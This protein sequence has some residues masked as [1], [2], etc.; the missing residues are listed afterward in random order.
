MSINEKNYLEKLIKN[1]QEKEITKID[2]LK[3]LDQKVKTPA[4]IFA[5]IFGIIGALVLGFGMCVA[6]EII[7]AGYF[8]IGIV[9]GVFGIIMVSI[10]YLIY[11]K[12]LNSRKHKYSNKI[13]ELSKSLLNA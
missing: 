4:N 6:M 11:K 7:L 5:Y 9:V 13:I 1:Y 3:A 2:E 10:N 12:I 8:W